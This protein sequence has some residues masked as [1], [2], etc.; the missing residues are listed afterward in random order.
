MKLRT[1]RT[2]DEINAFYAMI[3]EQYPCYQNPRI[4]PIHYGVFDG[5]DS[6][7]GEGDKLVAG[8]AISI[9]GRDFF[10]E[11]GVKHA[12]FDSL[13]VKPGFREFGIGTAL[14]NFM[15]QSHCDLTV[16]LAVSPQDQLL[17]LVSWYERFGFYVIGDH[18]DVIMERDPDDD[19]YVDASELRTSVVGYSGN[20]RLGLDLDEF[21]W[22]RGGMMDDKSRELPSPWHNRDSD[23]DVDDDLDDVEEIEF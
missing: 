1:L 15:V 8:S 11:E 18:S 13:I 7:E 16:R 6:S 17:R 12:V 19:P 14:F 2:L 5:G 23:T 20:T 21:W 9:D 22:D 3:Q 10:V 4:S